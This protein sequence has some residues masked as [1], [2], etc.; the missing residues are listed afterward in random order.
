MP[1]TIAREDRDPRG[2]TTIFVLNQDEVTAFPATARGNVSPVAL[3]RDMAAPQGIAHDSSGRIYIS[4]SATSTIAVYPA[5]TN[6]NVAPLA[7]IG[8]PKTG[9]TVPGGVALDPSGD[10]YVLNVRRKGYSHYQI[11]VFPPLG[12]AVG[13]LDEPPLGTIAGPKAQLDFPA[14]IAI[15]SR[16]Y[17]Y[18]ANE[19]LKPGSNLVGGRITVYSPGSKGDVGPVNVI[20]GKRTQLAIPVALAVDPAGDIYVANRN[21]VSPSGSITFNPSV[22]YFPAGSSGNTPPAAV[23][24]DDTPGTS[25][26]G[27]AVDASGNLAVSIDSG[28]GAINVYAPGSDG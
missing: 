2:Q 23:I 22:S 19:D 7:V 16:G 26:G 5:D 13:I 28:S 20:G 6:G 8:G 10:I 17:I 4:N 18:V 12:N 3:T 15:D 9:L 24:S 11:A 27:L 25:I 21:T 14:G 1:A